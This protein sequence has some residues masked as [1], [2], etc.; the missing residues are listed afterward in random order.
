MKNRR[1]AQVWSADLAISLVV[2]IGAILIAYRLI[3]NTFEET[4]YQEVRM[5]ALDAAEIIA[6]EGYPSAWTSENVIRAGI[7]SDD[8]LSPRK[9]REITNLEYAELKQALRITDEVYMYFHNS[10]DILPFFGTC[11]IGGTS[12][13]QVE[14]NRTIPTM[15]IT[16]A[17]ASISPALNITILS[18][19]S[20]YDVLLD[21]D[22]IVIEGNTS[23][24]TSF[25][26][27]QISLKMHEFSKRGGTAIML[28]HPG[29][30]L[31]GAIFNAS[32]T[33][34][35]SFVAGKGEEMGFINGDS[36]NFG[37]EITIDT[38]LS[39]S[40]EEISEY[41]VL[42]T[43]D[44]GSAAIAKWIHNDAQIIYIA[45]PFGTTANSTDVATL[46][47]NTI[48][49]MTI[50]DW[51]TCN[52]FSAPTSAKQVSYQDR[53]IAYHDQIIGIRTVTWRTR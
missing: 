40:G 42:A 23:T 50:T 36:Y 45:H 33:T 9:I 49:T 2:F 17:G 39:I 47:T 52:S 16:R 53:A 22:I 38:I 34:S 35:I 6:S 41:T 12:V 28:G 15:A 37:S 29:T 10:T 30:S 43:A 20:A 18:N 3:S 44:D 26:S 13:S 5:Q 48:Q 31:F 1:Q 24:S 11:G 51:P 27:D 7:A 32:N 19:D 46:I 14:G 25:T 8:H 4:G 21:Q